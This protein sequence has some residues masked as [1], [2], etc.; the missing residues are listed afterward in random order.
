MVDKVG[1][2]LGNQEI[3]GFHPLTMKD[4]KGRKLNYSQFMLLFY[5]FS[6]LKL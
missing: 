5:T 3:L 4:H 2:P 1:R 6:K